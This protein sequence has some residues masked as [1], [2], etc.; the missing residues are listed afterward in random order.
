MKIAAKILAGFLLITLA[1]AVYLTQ[2]ANRIQKNGAITLSVLDQPVTVRRDKL[3][4]PY[5]RAESLADALRAQ[6]FIIGQDRLYQAQLFR[7][8]ALGRLSEVFGER[9]LGNDKLIRIIGIRQ[10]SEKQLAALDQQSI[11]F[12]THYIEGLNAYIEHHQH[13]HP[14]SV[15]MLGIQPE[16][17]SLLDIIT[18]QIFQA[19]SNGSNWKMDIINQQLV[20]ELG[21]EKAQNFA[22]LTVNPDDESVAQAQLL[23]PLSIKFDLQSQLFKAIPEPIYYGSNA[24]AT[25]AR[26]SVNGKPILASSPHLPATTLPGFWLPMGIITPELSAAG[27]AAPGSPGIGVG[28]TNHIAYAATV[29]GSDGADLY[30]ETLDQNNHYLEGDQSFPLSIREEFIKVK[31]GEQESGFRTE[32]LVVRSSR[33][34]PLVSDHG[35]VDKIRFDDEN[36][37]ISLRWAAL[38]STPPNM[39]SDRLLVAENIDQAINAIADSPVALSHIVTDTQGG[40]ARISGG[41]VP[42]RTLGDGA[43]PVSVTKLEDVQFDNWS[44]LIP[45][46]EMPREVRPVHDW[47]GTANHRIIK[48][49]YPYQYSKIFASSWRY[50]RIKESMENSSKMDAGDHWRLINDVKNPL[51]E[52]LSPIIVSALQNSDSQLW[53]SRQL[54]EWDCFDHPNAIAPTIFQLTIKHL[55]ENL[56]SKDL[57]AE[58]SP[59]LWKTIQDTPYLWQE[60]LAYILQNQTN[61]PLIQTAVSAALSEA[62]ATLGEDREKWQWGKLHTITFKSPVIPGKSVANWLGG[63]THPMHGSGETLNRGA[64]K[65]SKG[66]DSDVIDSVRLIADMSDD[67]KL[68]AVIPGGSSGRYFDDSLTNQVDDWLDG[69][70][71]PIWFSQEAVQANTRTILTLSPNN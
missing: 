31:D 40:I 22:Q 26:K 55:A 42:I 46:A 11:D 17:W 30:I 27:V 51:A 39:G 65:L 62:E 71:N 33:R 20:D 67:D 41:R 19:W 47:V 66:F 35:I 53:A 59:E 8:L 12:Y 49:D 70:A 37:A 64:F 69:R 61:D 2:F 13:E 1:G 4:I 38:Q 50:R 63:G 56:F 28:R 21:A 32:T 9:G 43:T 48:R 24:W 45:T 5:I 34:G 16:P 10:F 3:D 18:L 58:L 68:L 15:K 57:S 6:G 29:G 14:L 23:S 52:R 36:K 7:L 54:N 25:G 44:G 60:R